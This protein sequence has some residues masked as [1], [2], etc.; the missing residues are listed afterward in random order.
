MDELEKELQDI[1]S[2]G[3]ARTL[4][5]KDATGLVN[6]SSNDYLGLS[7]HPAVRAAAKEAIDAWGTGGTSSRLLAG[8]FPPH[9]EL[10]DE[11]AKFLR[12]DAALAFS[13]GYHVNTGLLPAL[14]TPQ[15]IVFFDRLCHA[16]VIDGIRLSGARFATFHHNDVNH[17]ASFLKKQRKNYRRAFVVT[18]GTFSMDGDLPPL[19]DLVQLKK[20]WDLFLYLD[21]AHS[22]GLFGPDGRGVAARDGVL[23]DIDLFVGTLSKSIGGQGGFMA[24]SKTLVQLLISKCRSFI[25]TTA[26]AP[27]LAASA[28]AALR[29]FP[30]L[31]DRRTL[32]LTEAVKLRHGLQALG[33]DTL[34]SASPIVPIW[35]GTV[36]ETLKLSDHLLSRGYFVP[37]IRPP[38]VPQGEGR[39]RVSVTYDEAQKGTS[40]L[41]RALE[42]IPGRP[43]LRRPEQVGKTD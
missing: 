8:T 31:E 25:Y 42:E 29:L 33:Y 4:R 19:R 21:E 15:D 7:F 17:L 34:H 23:E 39:L 2:K 35:T 27:S 38:T 40:G 11:L 20:E 22:F 14:C 18:E 37:S 24:G 28:L 5:L 3:L 32:V 26:L 16:S 13:S 10:E 41:L 12:K 1:R 30:Q 6:F 36:E 43:T 9:V